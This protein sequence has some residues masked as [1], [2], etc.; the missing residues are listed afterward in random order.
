MTSHWNLVQ[1]INLFRPP[2]VREKYP[3]RGR[4]WPADVS[5]SWSPTLARYIQLSIRVT[6]ESIPDH[7]CQSLRGWKQEMWGSLFRSHNQQPDH[8][9]I[10]AVRPQKPLPNHCSDPN[11]QAESWGLIKHGNY[12]KQCFHVCI[13]C[14]YRIHCLLKAADTKQNSDHHLHHSR[15]YDS[16]VFWVVHADDWHLWLEPG[17]V[18]TLSLWACQAVKF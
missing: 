7:H 16:G 8:L 11:T 4:C 17:Q 1:E 18:L 10:V 13:T 6:A 2:A 5:F 14:C 15:L 3:L 12:R 9:V